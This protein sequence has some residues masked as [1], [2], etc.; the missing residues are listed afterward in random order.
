[1]TVKK[2]FSTLCICIFI[3]SYAIAQTNSAYDEHDLW[4][5]NFYPSSVNEYRAADGAPGPKHWTNQASYKNYATLDDVKDEISGN[6]TITYTNNSPQ[7][8]PF[9]WLYLDQNLYNLDSRGQAK[10]PATRRSRYGNV[11]SIFKGGVDLKSVKIISSQNGKV[12]ETNADTLISDTRMQIRL[13][14]PLKPNG[15]TITIKIAYS[16]PIPA[17]TWPLWTC[18]KVRSKR[19]DS[20]H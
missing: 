9:L 11:N 2:L 8:L 18:W 16:F 13:K 17:G 7:A 6:V 10:M 12:S 19:V 20:S 4:N 1:M 14:E 5:P 15:G 3:G